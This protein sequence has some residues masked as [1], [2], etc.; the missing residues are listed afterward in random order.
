MT[1]AEKYA[2]QIAQM[3]VVSKNLAVC[4]AFQGYDSGDC[5]GCPMQKLNCNN[6]K[7][8]EDWLKEESD[9]HA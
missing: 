5:K 4:K 1:N 6:L 8:V 3:I 2:E 9:P 7:L